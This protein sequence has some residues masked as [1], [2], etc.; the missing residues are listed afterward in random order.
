MRRRE[1]GRRS[2]IAAAGIVIAM[3]VLF[4]FAWASA[5]DEI[6]R[7]GTLNLARYMEPQTLNPNKTPE[8]GC[9]WVMNQVAEALITV[10]ETG[11][12]LKPGIAESWTISPD[13]LVYT[14][15]LREAKFSN[16]EPVTA[17]DVVF[18]LDRAR[19]PENMFGWL[20]PAFDSVEA[21]DSKTV[22]VTLAEPNAAILS[23]LSFVP[24]AIFQ[25][26]SC[27]ADLEACDDAP[28]CSGPFMVK[29]FTR[30]VRVVLVRNPYYWDKGADGLPLPYLDQVNILYIPESGAR[31]MGLRK[32]EFDAI[33]HLP[34][35]LVETLEKVSGIKVEVAPSYRVD[36][37][38]LNHKKAPL[39]DKRI[40]LALNYAT[41]HEAIRKVVYHGYG[42]I[43]NSYM[44]PIN[45]H[46]DEVASIPF[47]LEK[48]KSLIKEAGYD[49]T[50]IELLVAAG[51]ANERKVVSMLQQSWTQAGLKVDLVEVDEGTLV[52]KIV[53]SD[54]QAGLAYWTSDIPD[55]DEA[56]GSMADINAGGV[57]SWCGYD[58]PR[59]AELAKAGRMELDPEKRRPIY[60]ELQ[61]MIYNDALSVPI[62]Y[63]PYV[64]A[65][66]D[67]VKNW[68]TLATGWWWLKDVW[69]DK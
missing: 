42:E 37:I 61:K 52:T 30:G 35:N 60:V 7:G 32:G 1:L 18:S 3:L 50:P 22:R 45:F 33:T 68:A 21:V 63:P 49:G 66:R 67:Y 55:E 47:D 44:E 53:G 20:Y 4:S 23:T 2:R 9:L 41:D 59:A 62:I 40:R 25:K 27:E 58:N 31:V 24:G 46:S 13:K 6:K 38:Y 34:L 10:D 56:T 29:E 17:E 8:N 16:G 39:N 51:H 69:L 19:D 15:K 48:A 28:I 5:A 14:F 12:G 65:Y 36:M 57:A 26:S 43:P 64:N 11:R 54:F